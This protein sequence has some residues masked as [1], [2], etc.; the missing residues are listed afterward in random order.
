[1]LHQIYGDAMAKFGDK[2]DYAYVSELE[3]TEHRL[4]GA[5]NNVLRDDDEPAPV[6][7]AVTSYLPTVKQHHDLMRDRKWAME[8][9]H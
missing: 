5:W 1:V 8:T 4:L 7:N 3:E 2:K 9:K 6:K